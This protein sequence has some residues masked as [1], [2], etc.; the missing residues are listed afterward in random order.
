MNKLRVPAIAMGIAL[1]TT[2]AGAAATPALAARVKTFVVVT[3]NNATP[4]NP[5]PVTMGAPTAVVTVSLDYNTCL[6]AFNNKP[7]GLVA[8]DDNSS[9]ITVTPS[10]YTTL[11]CTDSSRQFTLTGVANGGATIKFN[12]DAPKGLEGQTSGAQVNVVSSGFSTD[13]GGNPPGHDRPAAPAVAN[14]FLNTA[15]QT[16][17]CKAAYDGDKNWHG[18]FIRNVAKW[19]AV[20]HLGKAKDDTSQFPLDTDWIAYVQTE[21]D[22]LC[23]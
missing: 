13:G 7:F 21:V 15:S 20:H 12:V 23:S 17:A 16:D 10:F 18:Q 8:S 22:M 1:A 6:Q 3:Y 14:G 11:L 4:P 9:A 2:A 19:Q 5:I